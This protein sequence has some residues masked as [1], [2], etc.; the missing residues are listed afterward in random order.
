MYEV[1]LKS[2][3]NV[4]VACKPLVVRL[5]ADSCHK[6]HTLQSSLRSDITLCS[7]V[8][9]FCVHYFNVLLVLICDRTTC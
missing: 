2:Y 6:L 1:L 9:P 3:Q 8:V 4:Y 7:R 5:S